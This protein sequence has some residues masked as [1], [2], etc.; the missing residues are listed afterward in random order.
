M[1][2]GS[3]RSMASAVAAK[4]NGAGQCSGE[5][6]INRGFV[7]PGEPTTVGSTRRAPGHA[8]VVPEETS[9]AEMEH[10]RRG[11]G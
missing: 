10:P 3:L 9:P 7:L 2:R 5:N 8:P 11:V 1:N 6:S 4:G